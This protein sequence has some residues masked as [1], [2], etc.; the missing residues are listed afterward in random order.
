VQLQIRRFEETDQAQV[1]ALW[2]ECG[3]TRAWNDPSKDIARKLLVQR[4]LFLVGVI[5][6]VVVTTAMAGYDGH[7]GW[8]NY[9]GVAVAHRSRGYALAMMHRVEDLLVEMG[10]PKVNLQVR[11]SN[12]QA[13]AFYRRIGYGQD[14]VVSY[15]K[16][17][18][19]DLPENAAH[20][21]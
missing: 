15:G 12:A 4:E 19:P 21:K 17:L 10:C 8:I 6:G 2:N 9:L 7:R 5:D 14:E 20:T 3:L 16:R 13:L 11:A 18:I 1:I